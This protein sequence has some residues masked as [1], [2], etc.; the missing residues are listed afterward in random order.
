MVEGLQLLAMAMQVRARPATRSRI[1]PRQVFYSQSL[2]TGE[3]APRLLAQLTEAGAEAIPVTPR[4]MNSLSERD[5]SQGLAATFALRQ[6]E[7]SRAEL[8]PVISPGKTGPAPPLL[9]FLDK[10]QDPGNLGTLIRTADAVGAR[11]VILLE[12][13]VDPFDP[14]TVRGTMGSIF[15]MPV[16]RTKNGEQ[17]LPYLSKMGYHLVGADARRGR[18]VWQSQLLAGPVALVLGNEA[19]GLSPELHGRLDDYVSLPLRSQVESLNVSIA[20]GVLM[21]EW[22]RVNANE[23]PIMRNS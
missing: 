20:G 11:A 6:L 19:R 3:T 13:C 9:L 22:L 14:K 21:Y 10:L 4:I 18:S 2:F 5:T 23:E 1:K 8:E 12:P 7:W 17:F 15:T 16:A